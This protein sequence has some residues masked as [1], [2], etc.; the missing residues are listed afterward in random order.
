MLFKRQMEVIPCAMG[1]LNLVLAAKV[2]SICTGL[3]SPTIRANL[4][5]SFCVRVNFLLIDIIKI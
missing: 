4:S 5:I 1:V 3:K 2:G